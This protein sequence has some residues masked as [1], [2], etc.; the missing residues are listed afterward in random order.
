MPEPITS[1][2]EVFKALRR[3]A[4]RSY[5]ALVLATGFTL[6]VACIEASLVVPAL[7]HDFVVRPAL[8]AVFGHEPVPTAVEIAMGVGSGLLLMYRLL[9]WAT[10]ALWFWSRHAWRRPV[11]G[12]G[13]DGDGPTL[14]AL[15]ATRATPAYLINVVTILSPYPDAP[16]WRHPWRRWRVL[17]AWAVRTGELMAEAGRLADAGLLRCTQ[18]ARR[19]GMCMYEATDLGRDVAVRNA[20]MLMNGLTEERA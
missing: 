3:P 7:V 12:S 6:Y 20:E 13:R 8:A 11:S 18:R 16:S 17:T 9:P 15:F 14:L 1:W 10:R 5:A 2:P 4:G 19:H